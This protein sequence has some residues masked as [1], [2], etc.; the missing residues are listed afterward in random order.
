MLIFNETPFQR[1]TPGDDPK[2]DTFNVHLNIEERAQLNADKLLLQQTKDSTALKQLASIGSK[3][4]HDPL[5]GGFALIIMDNIRR[6]A[7]SGVMQE[8][9]QRRAKVQQKAEDCDTNESEGC[10]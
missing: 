5:L 2:K 9:G 4:L 8:E 6:N 1:M 10:A 7:R 3:V